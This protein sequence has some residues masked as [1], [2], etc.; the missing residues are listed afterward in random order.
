MEHSVHIIVQQI[1]CQEKEHT[2]CDKYEIRNQPE[3]SESKENDEPSCERTPDDSRQNE[4][5]EVSECV[6]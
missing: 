5:K 3:Q 6:S 1:T 4:N 2:E